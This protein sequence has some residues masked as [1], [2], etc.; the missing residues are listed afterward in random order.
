VNEASAM[1]A[2]PQKL[3]V[4][5][6]IKEST[7]NPTIRGKS[8][9]YGLMQLMPGTAR[10]LGFTGNLSNLFDPRTNIGLGT[11]YLAKM[12]LKELDWFNTLRAY[13]GGPGWRRSITA[14]AKTLVYANQVAAIL[15][16]I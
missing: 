16:Q 1:Y 4:A 11:Q 13:N 10:E 15:A 3:I 9:E 14:Q 2:I 5:E 8:G 6:I 12:Y 7:G